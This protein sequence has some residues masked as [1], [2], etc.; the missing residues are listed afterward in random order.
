[1][2]EKRIVR[3]GE[4]EIRGWEEWKVKGIREEEYSIR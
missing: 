4:G 2:E 1:L 3:I